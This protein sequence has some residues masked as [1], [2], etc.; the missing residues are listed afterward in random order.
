MSSSQSYTKPSSKTVSKTGK[1]LRLN[2]FLADCGLGSR[3]KVEEFI[4][5][6][7]VKI[8]G[9][10]CLELAQRVDPN[11][12]IIE[13]DDKTLS[14]KKEKLYI[15][16]NKPRG[17]VVSQSDELGRET[18][19][20]LLPENASNLAYAGRL[21]KNS[22]GLLLF[23]ND[24]SL[25][26]LLT[27]PSYKVEKV[28]K[29][30][31][32]RPLRKKELDLL[33]SGVEIEG[34]I[35]HKAGVFVKEESEGSM[36]LKMVISEG[37]KR[38]IRQ[39]IEAVGA[40]VRKLK[41]LQFGPL[42]LKELPTGRWRHLE[43]GEVRALFS[44]RNIHVVP[45]RKRPEIEKQFEKPSHKEH[46][47]E[48]VFTGNSFKRGD[49]PDSV[50][51]ERPRRDARKPSAPTDSAPRSE[52]RTYTRDAAN[53][54]PQRREFSKDDT[55][56]RPQRREF[57]KDDAAPRPQRREFS[58]DDANPRAQ[59]RNHNSDLPPKKGEKRDWVSPTSPR[60]DERSDRKPAEATPYREKRSFS[61]DGPGERPEKRSFKR[62]E[63]APRGTKP[64]YKKTDS[65]RGPKKF[66]KPEASSQGEEK[67]SFK[68]NRPENQAAK[69][70]VKRD[71]RRK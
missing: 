58:K 46:K 15:L 12:D 2:R 33:R 41:R 45:E 68:L 50:R 47:S 52:K 62:D 63:A 56:P 51:P 37:R 49:K 31:I 14:A 7:R 59:K 17:Y 5:A 48:D 13:L 16:L 11:L 27:H 28:Y 18:V 6:G 26:N 64:A 66:G 54:R 23:T 55:N 36:S 67:R 20:A 25:I 42:K 35:T 53:P 40:K 38:Q 57:N 19:Y 1:D 22:E 10:V 39:M 70:I 65:A 44:E 24:T 60:K 32:D 69:K 4:S 9:T 61:K 30:D 21:D 34:G 29:V 8:N 71:T 43:P 3:R